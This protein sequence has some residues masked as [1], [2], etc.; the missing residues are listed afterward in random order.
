MIWPFSSLSTFSYLRVAEIH[1]DILFGIAWQ[2][3]SHL[4]VILGFVDIHFY[5][6]EETILEQRSGVRQQVEETVASA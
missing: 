6:L 5:F 4:V 2:I 3:G 1:S